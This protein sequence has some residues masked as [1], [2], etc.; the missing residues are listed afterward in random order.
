ME[1]NKLQEY[2]N[3]LSKTYDE[4][5]DYE[6]DY[7]NGSNKQTRDRGLSNAQSKIK[8]FEYYVEKDYELYSLLTSENATDYHKAIIWDE[9]TSVQYFSRDLREAIN[10]IKAIINEKK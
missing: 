10:K 1:K 6:Y 4:Y 7:K 3:F 2:L 9:F 5:V 8:T